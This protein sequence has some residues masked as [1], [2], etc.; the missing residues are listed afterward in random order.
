VP[1]KAVGG[2]GQMGATAG[3]RIQAGY[4][5]IIYIFKADKCSGRGRQGSACFDS[6][7]YVIKFI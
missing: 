5:G 3:P 7:N 6:V 2:L 1:K 4:M